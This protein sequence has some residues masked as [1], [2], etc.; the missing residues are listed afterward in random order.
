MEDFIPFGTIIDEFNTHLKN[1]PKILFSAP[2]GLGKTTFLKEFFKEN[3]EYVPIHLFPVNYSISSNEDILSLLKYDIL[4]S[5]LM[6]EGVLVELE[7]FKPKL[8]TIFQ[9]TLKKT[10]NTLP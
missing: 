7:N 5:L 1:N 8:T 2:Y 10:G 9:L 4:V 3:E 6:N